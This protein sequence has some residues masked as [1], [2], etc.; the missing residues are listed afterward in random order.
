MGIHEAFSTEIARQRRDEAERIA[1]RMG[2]HSAFARATAV[3]SVA[4]EHARARARA[5]ADHR[6]A[7]RSWPIRSGWRRL[8]HS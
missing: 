6:A 3:E 5:R 1:I 7:R 8:I 4:A 2:F